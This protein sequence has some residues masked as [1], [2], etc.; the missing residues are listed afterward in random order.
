M[1]Q[2]MLEST[3]KSSSRDHSLAVELGEH[4]GA[5]KFVGRLRTSFLDTLSR[6][7]QGLWRQILEKQYS[8]QVSIGCMHRAGAKQKGPFG[9]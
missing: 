5:G 1:K 4:N 8:L 9:V 3:G 6:F 7:F 2:I